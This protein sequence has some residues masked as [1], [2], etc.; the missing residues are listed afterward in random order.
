[1][2]SKKYAKLI[3]YIQKQRINSSKILKDLFDKVDELFFE[4]NYCPSCLVKSNGLCLDCLSKVVYLGRAEIGSQSS[5]FTGYTVFSYNGTMERLIYRYKMK[6]DYCS[7]HAMLKLFYQESEGNKELNAFLKGFDLI[8]FVPSSKKNIR[9]K[10]FNASFEMCHEIS[11][12][13]KIPMKVLFQNNSEREQKKLSLSERCESISKE[14]KLLENI[15]DLKIDKSKKI[16]IF[17]DIM[18]SGATISHA[19]KLLREAGYE[20]GFL[21]LLRRI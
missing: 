4:I 2:D 7:F 14:L 17:D 10:A 6:Q 13:Y 20:T 21:T 19:V 3:N 18:T 11:K 1:M 16:L 5:I 12:R 9:K 15:E 8:S